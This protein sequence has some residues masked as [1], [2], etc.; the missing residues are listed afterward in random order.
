MVFTEVIIHAT[1]K[2]YTIYIG[3]KDVLTADKIA[4]EYYETYYQ[5]EGGDIEEF[6]VNIIPRDE[7]FAK[8]K[9]ADLQRDS[10]HKNN[11]E[12]FLIN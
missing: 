10:C 2:T 9:F 6:E 7:F 8:Y 11:S 1:Y 3:E 12:I 4:R 5:N